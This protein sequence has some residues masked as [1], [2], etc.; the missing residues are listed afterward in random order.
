VL[1][2]GEDGWRLIAE[3][4]GRHARRILRLRDEAIPAAAPLRLLGLDSLMAMELRNRVQHDFQVE[5][6]TS[7]FLMARGLDELAL[8]VLAK[9]R[10]FAPADDAARVLDE[11]DAGSL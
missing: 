4:M 7:R 6:S 8:E 10:G 2:A 5:L 3:T 1:G 11:M 9:I